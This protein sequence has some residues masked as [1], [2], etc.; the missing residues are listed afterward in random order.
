[1]VGL[2]PKYFRAP[3]GDIDAR[4]TAVIKAMGLIHILWD[5]DSYDWLAVSEGVTT[6]QIV[7]NFTLW[8]HD[9]SV[10]HISLQHEVYLPMEQFASLNVVSTAG[11]NMKVWKFINEIRNNLFN[12][13]N[14]ITDR[15]LMSWR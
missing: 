15:V 10:G 1:M 2:V 12:V 4:V 14:L 7:A 8:T 3:F 5:H 11:F 13:Q 9:L 6:A